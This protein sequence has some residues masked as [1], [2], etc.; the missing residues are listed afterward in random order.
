MQLPPNALETHEPMEREKRRDS[1]GKAGAGSLDTY[2]GLGHVSSHG[3]VLGGLL[4][5]DPDALLGG[6]GREGSCAFLPKRS[7]G[8]NGKKRERHE[9]V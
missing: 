4:V 5:G 9:R 6:H 8:G 1:L 2:R 7:V 3:D